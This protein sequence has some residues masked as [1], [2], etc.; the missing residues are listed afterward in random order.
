MAEKTSTYMYPT[1]AQTV[2]AITSGLAGGIGGMILASRLKKAKSADT[3]SVVVASI[4]SFT[5]TFLAIY[6][7][8]PSD[9][10]PN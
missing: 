10:K 9:K 6:L 8:T 4:V 7:I 5:A 2:F 1:S 3:G